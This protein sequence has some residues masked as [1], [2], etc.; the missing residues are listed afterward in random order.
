MP[1][2]LAFLHT[3]QVHVE[4]FSCLLHECG[5][6]LN[7]RHVVDESLLE[8]ARAAGGITAS[9]TQRIR[10]TM[11]NATTSGAKGWCV[12]ARQLVKLPNRL[13]LDRTLIDG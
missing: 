10:E 12:H 8:D 11:H 7:A 1:H 2:D 13:V 4:T 6:D 3:A 9:L 5:P